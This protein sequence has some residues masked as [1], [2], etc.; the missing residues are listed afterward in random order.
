[1][2]V[3]YVRVSSCFLLQFADIL[4]LISFK[5]CWFHTASQ[6]VVKKPQGRQKPCNVVEVHMSTTQKLLQSDDG[7]FPSVLIVCV[8]LVNMI[9]VILNS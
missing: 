1:M 6:A 8:M 2:A 3:K 4:L 5:Q 9:A 7:L